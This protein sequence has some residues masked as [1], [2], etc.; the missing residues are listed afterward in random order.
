MRVLAASQGLLFDRLGLGAPS[1]TPRSDPS[2]HKDSL[3]TPSRAW[4]YSSLD[5]LLYLD[6]THR[7][8][9]AG[10]TSN[11]QQHSSGVRVSL[12][13]PTIS[14]RCMNGLRHHP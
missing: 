2:A 8:T 14:G 10:Q 6:L 4:I 13:R 3:F 11:V 1:C 5:S 12:L 7:L 9:S